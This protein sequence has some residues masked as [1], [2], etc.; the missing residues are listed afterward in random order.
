[1]MTYDLF[2][3]DKHVFISNLVIDNRQTD[4]R[5]IVGKLLTDM[6]IQ[7]KKN[8]MN[9]QIKKIDMN[10]Q[11]EKNDINIQNEKNDMNEKI[12][13]KTKIQNNA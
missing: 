8:D 11:N 4:F 3:N 13:K 1:M 2:F 5:L 12:I 10:I 7:N 9:I 6:N